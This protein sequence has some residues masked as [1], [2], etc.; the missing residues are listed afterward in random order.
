MKTISGMHE[1]IKPANDLIG[2][3]LLPTLLNSIVPEVDRQLYWL[4]LR[5]GGLGIPILSEIAKSQ[6]EA[7]QAITLPVV[8]II[9][10]QNKTLSNETEIHEI[11][12]KIKNEQE[13]RTSERALIIFHLFI[14][15][16]FIYRWYIKIAFA[17]KF[18]PYHKIQ[19]NIY[20]VSLHIKHPQSISPIF[21]ILFLNSNNELL[22]FTTAGRLF[23]IREPRK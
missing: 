15:K 10:T 3:E 21:L 6:F 22:D 17:N 18:Q 13:V 19:Y 14:I 11:K 12:R 9:I 8:I 23:H 20:Y 1:F 7:S 4:P 5:H 2:L 16:N